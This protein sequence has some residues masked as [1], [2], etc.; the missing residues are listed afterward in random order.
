MGVQ[1]H[2]PQ[3]A[4]S[5]VF[6]AVTEIRRN[7]AAT[8]ARVGGGVAPPSTPWLVTTAKCSSA[9][10]WQQY[11]LCGVRGNQGTQEACTIV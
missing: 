7:H 11:L 4:L 1:L 2:V 9:A 8:V 5:E 10:W 6:S 3:E